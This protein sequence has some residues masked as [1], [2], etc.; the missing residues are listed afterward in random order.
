[1]FILKIF[2][3][4]SG[5][6][7]LTLSSSFKISYWKEFYDWKFYY[8]AYKLKSETPDFRLFKLE[9]PIQSFADMFIQ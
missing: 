5:I 8:K 3:K 6:N 1:M 7:F 9:F 4:V 2:T